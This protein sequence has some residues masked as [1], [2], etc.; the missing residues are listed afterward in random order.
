MVFKL[1]KQ[2]IDVKPHWIRQHGRLLQCDK[3]QNLDN[4]C[5][6]GNFREK[7]IF[8][9]SVKIHICGFKISRL[10]PDLPA[11]GNDRVISSFPDS[12]IF[13]EV[14]EIKTLAKTS[15]FTV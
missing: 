2:K 7:F 6:S 5:K 14:R 8:A 12:F 11:L 3:Y 1:M 15:E 10:G 4:Y 9:N 13:T